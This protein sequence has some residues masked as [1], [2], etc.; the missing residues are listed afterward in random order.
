MQKHFVHHTQR[1]VE[2]LRYLTDN[3]IMWQFIVEKAPWWGGFW[4]RLIQ[5]V[6]RP[7][8]RVI[9][10]ANLTYD[11]LQTLVVE[12]EGLITNNVH[13][14]RHRVTLTSSI[15]KTDYNDAK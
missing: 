8:R 7:L 10:R 2:V 13:V 1:F 5:S 15:W 14:P 12:I 4:E 3:Q 6:K 9:G 11:E